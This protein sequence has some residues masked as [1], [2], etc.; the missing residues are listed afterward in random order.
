MTDTLLNALVA[1]GIL[2]L[3]FVVTD[4][5]VRRMYYRCRKCGVLNAKRRNRCRGCGASLP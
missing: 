1:L 4:L 5:F 2:V 3:S